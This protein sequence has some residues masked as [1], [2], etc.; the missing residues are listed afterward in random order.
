MSAVRMWLSADVEKI[1]TDIGE[2]T[3][4]DLIMEVDKA[5]ADVEFTCLVVKTLLRSVKMD[6][7]QDDWKNLLKEINEI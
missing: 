3:G 6:M 7:S 1:A 5:V 4:F 2:N